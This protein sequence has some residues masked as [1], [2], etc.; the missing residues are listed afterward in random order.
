LSIIISWTTSARC[1]ISSGVR[2]FLIMSIF[3][4]GMV[5]VLMVVMVLGIDRFSGLVS[6]GL[7]VLM[8]QVQS[9][10]IF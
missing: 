5:E 2:T 7:G 3:T 4:S 9:L 1:L 10:Y 8:V 6:Y